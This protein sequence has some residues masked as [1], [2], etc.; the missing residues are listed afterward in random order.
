MTLKLRILLWLTPSLLVLFLVLFFGVQQVLKVSLEPVIS[1]TS[2]PFTLPI[3]TAVAPT[4]A[5]PTDQLTGP[6]AITRVLPSELETRL[7]LTTGVTAAAPAYFVRSEGADL[8]FQTVPYQ[9][10]RDLPWTLTSSLI[11]WGVLAFLLAWGIGAWGILR[12]LKP[13][14]DLGS[15]ISQR[16]AENLRPL[17]APLV[18]E[19]K[20]SIDALNG[21]FQ[22]MQHTL[23]RRRQQEEAARRFAYGASHELRNPL[24]ALRLYLD[25][26]RANP[27][28]KRAWE[29]INA[30]TQRTEKLLDSLLFLARLEGQ[31]EPRVQ[32]VQ[33]KKLFSGVFHGVIRGDARVQAD[34]SLLELALRNLLENAERHA[35]AV[36]EV[37]IE[38]RP[39]EVWIFVEDTGPGIPEV[40][41][42]Q[43]F[44]PFVKQSSGTG[45]GLALVKAVAQVHRGH[46]HAENLPN[47]AK[48]GFSVGVMPQ[49]HAEPQKTP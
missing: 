32:E 41:L 5:R 20:R 33:L 10:V 38:T 13:L 44:D 14:L 49:G 6:T 43:V 21:L 45:M 4:Q 42:K 36:R 37:C 2:M 34:P 25:V 30:Q 16:N 15:E 3:S 35:T 27:Q 29:G 48:M 17:T 24:A 39:G 22:E 18:P 28:E 12:S 26:I 19:L 47:G 1:P 40:L 46:V 9:K 11:L 7:A 8:V 31:A 23:E